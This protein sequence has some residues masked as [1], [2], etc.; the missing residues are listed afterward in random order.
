MTIT[1]QKIKD[2]QFRQKMRGY[3]VVEVRTFLERVAEEY[4]G[5]IEKQEADE[6]QISELRQEVEQLR[7]QYEGWSKE[8]AEGRKTIE[9]L[10]NECRREKKQN[11]RQGRR[12]KTF[13]ITIDR[14]QQENNELLGKS[15]LA[16]KRFR[17]MKADLLKERSTHKKMQN[18]IQLLEKRNIQAKKQEEYL[19][20]TLAAADKF[21]EDLIQK[22]E[23]QASEIFNRTRKEIARLRSEAREELAH[24]PSEIKKMKEEYSR[25]R[26]TVAGNCLPVS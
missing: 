21:S 2:T 17:E 11:E 6:R 12:L 7:I 5:R 9:H 4:L 15:D 19:K 1:P 25:V 24:F 18:A 16:H 3:D 13:Q 8:L 10:T 23:Q 14:L 20:K 22:S 26:G